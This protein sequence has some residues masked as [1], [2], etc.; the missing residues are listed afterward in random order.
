MR[1]IAL[2]VL[3]ADIKSDHCNSAPAGELNGKVVRLKAIRSV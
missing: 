2:I 3:E 1:G